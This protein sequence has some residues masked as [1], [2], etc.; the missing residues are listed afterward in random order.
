VDQISKK[1]LTLAAPVIYKQ[2][3]EIFNLSLKSEEYPYDWKLAKVS[4]VFKAG[5]PNDPNNFRPISILSTISR[6]FEKLVY[7]QLY[8]Y[9]T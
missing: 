1:V 5:E 9:L 6:V 2:L 7:E 3:T 4:P 8:N